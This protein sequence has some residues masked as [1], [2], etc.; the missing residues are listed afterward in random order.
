MGLPLVGMMGLL[1]TFGLQAR[2][3]QGEPIGERVR[4][5]VK[6]EALKNSDSPVVEIECKDGK[7][8]KVL[9]DTGSSFSLYPVQILK[10]MG[11][12]LRPARNR[13]GEPVRIFE[14]EPT[15]VGDFYWK[16]GEFEINDGAIPLSEKRQKVMQL[17]PL[18]GIVGSV[19]LKY[20][21]A[22]FDPEQK[23][24]TLFNWGKVTPDELKSLSMSDAGVVPISLKEMR[25]S[26][27][28]RFNFNA[29]T[30]ARGMRVV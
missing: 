16:L 9:L 22:Y 21:A 6:Y 27:E 10:Q 20:C 28:V 14:E 3:L 11:I 19:W 15:L 7:K 29:L 8:L 25:L 24:I 26:V 12:P 2:G 4:S 18:E 1:L 30:R 13:D 23:S 5:T 17:S